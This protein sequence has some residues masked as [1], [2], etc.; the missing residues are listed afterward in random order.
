MENTLDKDFEKLFGYKG[1]DVYRTQNNHLHFF[2]NEKEVAH[3]ALAKTVSSLEDYQKIAD[4]IIE[5]IE[6]GD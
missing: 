5:K 1:Y 6:L 4:F 2:K 3:C